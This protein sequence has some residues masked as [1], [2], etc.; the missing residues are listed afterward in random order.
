MVEFGRTLL[1]LWFR[2]V[3]PTVYCHHSNA[4]S[5]IVLQVIKVILKR[6]A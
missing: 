2:K 4:V 6:F 3:A 5:S 1:N